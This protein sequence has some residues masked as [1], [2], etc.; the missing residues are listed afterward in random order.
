MSATRRGALGRGDPGEQ[1]M[2]GVGRA[3]PAGPLV[4]V[5]R[6]R[7]GA[8]SSHQNALSNCSRSASASL[9]RR[10]RRSASPSAAASAR[11]AAL[12]GVDV[13][14]HLA[15]R[16]RAF[17][18][19]AVGVEDRVVRILPALLDQARSASARVLDEAVAVASP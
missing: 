14:L 11:R 3:H 9:A 19:R 6:E 7:V 10:A 5:E 4:A 2:A 8:S 15:Q 18:E 17:G 12:G 16:D 1:R 13:A